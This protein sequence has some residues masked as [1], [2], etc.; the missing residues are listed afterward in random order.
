MWYAYH[1]SL[2]DPAY[3][4]RYFIC[5]HKLVYNYVELITTVWI[6]FLNDE[7]ETT[8]ETTAVTQ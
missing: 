4:D 6:T 3:D 7:Y 1:Y 5:Y 8:A 2:F